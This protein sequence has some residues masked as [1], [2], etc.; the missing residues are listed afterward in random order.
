MNQ[1]FASRYEWSTLNWRKIQIQVFKLQRRIYQ[2]SRRNEKKHVH[3][4]QRLLVRSWYARL[5]AVRRV[6]QDNRGRRTAGIDGIAKLSPIQRLQLA[7]T[8]TLNE[9]AQAVRRIWIAKRNGSEHRPLGIPV[10]ADRARQALVKLGLEPEWEA[11]FEPNSYGFRPGRSVHDAIGAIFNA[12]AH[13]PKYVLDADIAQC[14]D[15]IQH[16]VLLQKLKAP[17]WLERPIRGWLNAGVWERGQWYANDAGTPQGGVLSPLLAN[18][19]LHGLEQELKA[20]FPAYSYTEAG[21]RHRVNSPHVVRYADDFVVLHPDLTVV[22][23]AQAAIAQWLTPLGLHL[24]PSKTRIVHTL[25]AATVETGFDFLGFHIRQYPVGRTQSPIG[26]KTLIKP[27]KAAIQRH[28]QQLRALVRQYRGYSQTHLIH[29]LNRRILGWS[30]YYSSVVSSQCFRA[31]DD[32]LYKLL[33]WWTRRQSSSLNSHTK[34]ARYWGVNRGQGWVFCTREGLQV[35]AHRFTPI[36]RHVKVRADRSPFDG[37]WLYWASRRGVYPG[38]APKLA[39]LLQRQAGQCAHCGLF[40]D[41]E[42]VIEI[43]HQDGNRHHNQLTNLLALHRH[44]HD[45]THGAAA[46]PKDVSMTRTH[47]LR[48]RVR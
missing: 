11:K 28:R 16:P 32:Y 19:A 46:H 39:N 26:Y 38:V 3:R 23:A 37:N 15:Q 21:K 47:L 24:Q 9:R 41:W 25:G 33:M 27:S 48:S 14:F 43:H 6:S 7:L 20:Q 4:L 30:R 22:E 45:Q 42:S 36:R 12:I 1:T 10:M 31:V 2:A 18:I 17:P 8:L 13:Q 40:F 29:A 5:L 34:V 35:Q 44:C